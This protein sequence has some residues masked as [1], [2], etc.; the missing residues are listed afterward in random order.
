MALAFFHL[1]TR[2]GEI[3]GIKWLDVDVNNNRVRLWTRKRLGSSKEYD[4]LHMTSELH[5]A[6]LDV[7]I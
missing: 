5:S 2:H 3:F 4:C 1:A 6:L 7:G